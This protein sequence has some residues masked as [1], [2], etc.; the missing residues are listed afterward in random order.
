MTD[1]DDKNGHEIDAPRRH[2]ADAIARWLRTNHVIRRVATLLW[3]RTVPFLIAVLVVAPIGALIFPFF[4]PKFVRNAHRRR[5]YG[6]I[7]SSDPGKRGGTGTP[8]DSGPG[9]A[10]GNTPGGT[11]IPAGSGSNRPQP[12]LPA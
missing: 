2:L 3:G 5:K 11:I 8:R 7:L 1:D 12:G 10:P 6:V 4:V 9:P